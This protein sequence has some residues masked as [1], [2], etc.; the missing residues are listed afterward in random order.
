M[1]PKPSELIAAFVS[2][3]PFFRGLGSGVSCKP[4]VWQY[5]AVEREWSLVSRLIIYY[6]I[7]TYLKVGMVKIAPAGL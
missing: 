7:F 3:V 6:I 4:L 1:S 2:K 5:D